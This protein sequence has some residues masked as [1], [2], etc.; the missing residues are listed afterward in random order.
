MCIIVI[1]L[2]TLLLAQYC[3]VVESWQ[4]GVSRRD[5]LVRWGGAGSAGIITTVLVGA[6]V[7]SAHAARGAAELD[8]EYYMRDLLGGNK[9]E[10]NVLPS[11]MPV[12]GPPRVLQEPLLSA[13][14]NDDFTPSAIPVE[15]LVQ[16]VLLAQQQHG[17]TT[18]SSSQSKNDILK[19]IQE[20]SISIRDRASRSFY[21][22]APWE[23]PTVSDQYYLD[24]SAYALW[25]TAAELL[26]NYVDRDVFVRNTGRALYRK[27]IA[28]GLVDASQQSAAETAKNSVVATLRGVQQ[29]LDAFVK[30]NYCKAYLLGPDEPMSSR[31]S[32][33]SNS[34]KKNGKSAAEPSSS[35][36]NM[37]VVDELDDEALAN[38]GTVDFLVRIFEPATLGASLQITGEQ[39]RFAPDVVGPTLAAHWENA[40]DLA[41]TWEFY[42]VDP[43]YR[44]SI[45]CAY[46]HPK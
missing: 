32:S 43:V 36:P 27:M 20:K 14:L 13:L 26:P 10:G 38:G 11:A 3:C 23:N 4:Q 25:R 12:V 34:K 40:A 9:Q 5:A 44:V 28:T 6:P 8:L 30:S 41:A 29:I 31:S 16:T 22:R 35:P 7:E 24:L 18:S 33:S 15:M 19:E 2:L 1:R 21:T 37:M 46:S 42:F 39:S 17:R 45:T